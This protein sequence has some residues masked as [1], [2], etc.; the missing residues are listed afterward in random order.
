MA[1]TKS[2]FGVEAG[3]AWVDTRA[4]ENAQAI[5]NATGRTTTVTYDEAD[6]AGRIYGYYDFNNQF[7]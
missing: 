4:P 1:Q 6:L 3:Y 5:A 2:G 7:I